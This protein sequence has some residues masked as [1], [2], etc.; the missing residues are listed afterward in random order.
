MSDESTIT[1]KGQ[2]TI[3]S[4]LRKKL[5]LESGKKIV[6]IETDDGI[7]IKPLAHSMRS[8]R[9]IYSSDISIEDIK[10]AVTNIRKDWRLQIE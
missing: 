2:I 8:L 4:R 7:L 9:G 3:P 5:N 6:F 1:S 10:N